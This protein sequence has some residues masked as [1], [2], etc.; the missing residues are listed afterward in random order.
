[1]K[2]FEMFKKLRR[3]ATAKFAGLIIYYLTRLYS[4]TFRMKVENESEWLNYLEQGGRVLIC[5]WHQQ[6]FVGVRLFVRYRKY[7]V[8]V[9]V[10]KSLDGDISTRI[11]EAADVFP[12]RGSSSRSG[13]PALKEMISRLKHGH[14]AVLLPDGPRGPA[15]VV[16][17]GAIAVA[18]GAD[19]AIVPGYVSANRAWYVKS[20]DKFMVPKPFARVTVSFCPMMILPPIK[21]DHDFE[22]QRQL[23]ENTLKPYLHR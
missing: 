15:G 14:L 17:G 7:S 21:D 12:V 1:M 23:L 8:S 20:W 4:A 6:F 9:M 5:C 2:E 10:S 18:S 22:K 11:A 19:A 16:K 13:G 3:I